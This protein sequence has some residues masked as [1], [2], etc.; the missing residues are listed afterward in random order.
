MQW[1]KL[2]HKVFEL[3]YLELLNQVEKLSESHPD[4]FY[5][6]RLY[7]LLE[8]V[9]DCIQ[10]RI[11]QNPTA[12]AFLLGNTLGKSIETGAGPRKDYLTGIACSLSFLPKNGLLS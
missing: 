2:W 1:E 3:R 9:T 8:S 4:T 10:N 6:H 7:E 11:F 12:P 5:K